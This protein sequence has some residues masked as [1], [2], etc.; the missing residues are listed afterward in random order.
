MPPKLALL[1][2]GCAFAALLAGALLKVLV[3]VVW[4]ALAELFGGDRQKPPPDWH[5]QEPPACR[6]CGYDLRSSPEVCP[7]CGHRVDPL[8]GTIVR[9]LMSVG[10]SPPPGC[11]GGG[12]FKVVRPRRGEVR[13]R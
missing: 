10:H 11:D 5:G 12:G 6:A 1:L 13:L 9:Y 3:P 4:Q 2:I 8:D 7:E